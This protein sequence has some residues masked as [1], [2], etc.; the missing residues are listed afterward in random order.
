MAKSKSEVMVN[1]GSVA[2]DS[3]PEVSPAPTYPTGSYRANGIPFCS[4]CGECDR[5]DAYNDPLCPVSDPAC[6]RWGPANGDRPAS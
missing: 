2:N 6:E 5:V 4:A 3:T 1:E